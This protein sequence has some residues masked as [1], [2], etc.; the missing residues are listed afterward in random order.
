MPTHVSI[1]TWAVLILILAATVFG[2]ITA[3]TNLRR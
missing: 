2:I 1:L 3:W